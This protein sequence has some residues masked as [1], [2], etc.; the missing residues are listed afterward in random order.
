MGRANF[1]EDFKRDAVLQ[2]TERGYPLAEV[3]ARLG[4][5]KYPL[6]EWK[7]R[8]AKPAAAARDDDHVAEARRLKRE[9]QRVTEERDLP[10]KKRP[11]TSPRMQ[12]EARVHRRASPAVFD[13]RPVPLPRG[14]AQRLLRLA[15]GP[16]EPPR[17]RGCCQTNQNS[18]G[19]R[20][21]P[22]FVQAA[23]S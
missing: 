23:P 18:L 20:P 12:G 5:S 7:K 17:Q 4:I 15:E 6:Y 10:Q 3:A 8:Y 9:L 16:A 1:T 21:S 22:M 2:V 13:P 11:G 14:S 19:F